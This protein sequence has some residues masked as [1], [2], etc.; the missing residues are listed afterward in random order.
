MTSSRWSTVDG[1]LTAVLVH[2]RAMWRSIGS[3]LLTQVLVIALTLPASMLSAR[4]LGP[5]DLGLFLTAQRVCW[6]AILVL[7]LSAAHG[8]SYLSADT[9]DSSMLRRLTGSAVLFTVAVA[10]V[11]MLAAMAFASFQGDG[12]LVVVMTTIATYL[13]AF[14]LAQLLSAI[15]RGQLRSSQ[16]NV[17]RV[18]QPL[19][20]LAIVVY[21]FQADVRNLALLGVLFALAHWSAA[22]VAVFLVCRN[23]W[24]PARPRRVTSKVLRYSLRAHFGQ[25]GSE[26]NV[27]LDQVLLSLLLPFRSVGMYGV[28]ANT[29][30]AVGGISGSLLPIVQPLVQRSPEVQRRRT[31]LILVA[32]GTT[33]LGVIV[34]ALFVP[35]PWLIQLVYGPEFAP[36]VTVAR[37]LLVAVWLDAVG[38]LSGAVLFGI[39]RPGLTSWAAGI[40]IGVG[41]AALL[42]LV[43]RFGIEGAAW[44]SVGSYLVGSTMKVGAVFRLLSRSPQPQLASSAPG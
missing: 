20:W 29:A 1:R 3:M 21:V 25:A 27:Y 5:E 40:S 9:T 14:L 39:N 24:T 22:L 6:I 2:L 4:L 31:S 19:V 8:Y 23:G 36:A 42:L 17:V 33:I 28:G 43:P 37:I 13:P 44:A 26:L 11:A 7:H 41:V 34:I 30:A 38:S 15:M 35:M 16:F 18:C 10:P 32:A 12:R